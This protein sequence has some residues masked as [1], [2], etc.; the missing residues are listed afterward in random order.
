MADVSIDQ[1]AFGRRLKLFQERWKAEGGGFG[2][3][4]DITAI[5][6]AGGST[7]QDTLRYLKC[8]ALQHWLFGYELPDTILA[9]TK[10]SIHVVTSSK[11]G[12]L[13]QPLAGP[14]EEQA[15]TSLH[16]HVKPK[17]ED[18]STQCK[19]LIE[20]LQASSSSPLIGVPKDKLD[21]KLASVWSSVLQSSEVSTVDASPAIMEP[22]HVKDK[23]EVTNSKRAAFLAAR[24][25]KDFLVPKL[26]SVIDEERKIKQSRFAEEVDAAIQAPAKL[27]IKLRDDNVD[28]AYLTMLQS[29]G[30]YDLKLGVP[31]NDKNLAYDVIIASL[32]TRYVQYCANIAR[33]YLVDPS[34]AQEAEYAAI[35]AAQAK[36][37]ASMTEGAEL[38]GIVNVITT[39]LQEQKQEHLVPKLLKTMGHG[40]GIE[41][42][43]G[44]TILNSKAT[45]T[46]KAGMV[47]NLSIGVAGLQ[48]PANGK[49]NPPSY[50]MWLADTVLIKPD[51]AAPE[52][53]TVAAPK[54]WDD[55]AYFFKDEGGVDEKEN[56]DVTDFDLLPEGKKA[57]LRSDDRSFREQED[58][59]RRAKQNQ[60]E[61][62]AK[63]NEETLRSLTRARESGDE[64][65][66]SG[67]KV[68][69]LVT[70]R[71]IG[72]IQPQGGF[73]I[74]VDTNKEAVLVPLYGRLVPFHILT[75][76]NIS[77]NQDGD[78]AY[79]R[80]NFNF[81]PTFEPG[82]K[83][84]QAFF[85]KELSFRT[86]DTR[87]AAKAVQEVKALRGAVTAR[88]KER[89]ERATL[90]QQE[91]LNTR[92]RMFSLPDVWIRPNFGGKGRK[93]TGQLQAH[94][95]GFRYS[96]PKQERLDIMYRNIK[97]AFYQPAKGEMITLLHFHLINPIMVAK[98]KT[99]DVQFY[100]EVMDTVQTLDQGRRSMYDPDEI[101]E[102][103]REREQ[104]RRVNRQFL[105]FT[106]KVQ[107]E[108]WE[109]DF[110]DMDLEF[111][112][113]FRE[114]TFDGVPHKTAVKLLPTVNCLVELTEMPFTV[115]TLT[116]VGIMSLER[117]GF[118]LK[119]FD[120]AIVF[121][122]LTRDVFRIDAI[123]SQALDII[124]DW[125]SG[126]NI[127]FYESKINLNWKPILKNITDDPEGFI[128]AGGW[129]FLNQEGQSDEDEDE[130]EEGDAEFQPGSDSDAA[131]ESSEAASSEDD[132]SLE[133]ENSDED[134]EPESE[135][136][137]E[138]AGMDW[139]EL[140]QQAEREDRARERSDGDSDDEARRR[141]RK[142]GSGSSRPAPSKQQ[143]RR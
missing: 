75:V 39:T 18:G 96:T 107:K 44:G 102:E 111:E 25:M 60:D 71:S 26:E 57:N 83:D 97:H 126:I 6:V 98:R 138:E 22:L 91:A 114:L 95:N 72:E 129:D 24:V 40:M 5:V 3:A 67:R 142:G 17:N 61:L 12:N 131:A 45:G 48:R 125:L 112:V 8:T 64:P 120:L 42:R 80:L 140:E 105:N 85:L 30:D 16:L 20:A 54:A 23:D 81:G 10:D 118:A 62:L 101:E 132:A 76:R 108:I 37:I 4:D 14:A 38:A 89:A 55:V 53:L 139:D 15:Q 47:F 68:S 109:R 66:T 123:P 73:Q 41:L 121:K 122:D 36:A 9:F 19:D 93:M 92:G 90:V 110:G 137:D 56:E 141:K 70:Y 117:V 1:E 65:S 113:P 74:Q 33:T 82:A 94:S 136:S 7:H 124:R 100:T 79:I 84:P 63:V 115:I 32:G 58:L 11:K 88:E 13:I 50:G 69:D 99:A 27:E 29:G 87:H 103:Q 106:T 28:I 134:E 35:M 143:R 128:E 31:S 59:R 2:S 46:F 51:G 133:S 104:R 43:E 135:G 78:H 34:K 21:G 77:S 127:K 86:S 52:I 116:E 49:S 119:N 130:E